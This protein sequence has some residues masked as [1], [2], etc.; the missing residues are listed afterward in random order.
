MAKLGVTLEKLFKKIGLDTTAPELA[1]IVALDT[2]IPDDHANKLNTSLFTLDAAK[3]NLDLTKHFRATI[4]SVADTK[5]DE[6]ITELGLQP[7]DDFVNSKNTYEK[8]ALLGKLIH[9][10]GKKAGGGKPDD[11]NKWAAKEAEYQKQLKELK[12]GFT[13]KETNWKKEQENNQVTNELRMLL[14]GQNYALPKEMPLPLKVKTALA[15]IQ[16][17]LATDGFSLKMD[18]AGKLTIVNA[19]GNP[20]YNKSNEALTPNTYISAALAE[21]KLLAINDPNNP[22]PDPLNPGKVTVDPKQGN[23]AIVAEIEQQMKEFA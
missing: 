19:E 12:E 15:T 6:I 22:A 11:A 1:A 4:L 18:A 16:D 20:A 5:M 21:N 17:Q 8:I 10:H 23:A 2:E 9:E 14:S 7:G 3:S 13:A